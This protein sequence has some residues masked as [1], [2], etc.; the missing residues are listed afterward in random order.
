LHYERWKRTGDPLTP[1][2][3]PPIDRLLSKVTEDGNGCWIFNG[4]INHNGYGTLYVG[5]RRWDT[6]LT[7]RL[8]YEHFIT[9]IP[10]DLQMDHLCRARAC[11]NPWH[12]EP[13]T[14]KEN[15]LRGESPAAKAARVTECPRGHAYDDANTYSYSDGSR[16]C[17]ICRRITQQALRDSRKERANV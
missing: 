11:C 14:R 7:H 5:P 16:E 6:K 2:R 3:K 1:A 4:K 9:E 8:T 17:R 13:V 12:L 10:E 15:I